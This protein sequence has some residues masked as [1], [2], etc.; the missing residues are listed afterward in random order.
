MARDHD[1]ILRRGFGADRVL[2]AAR[3]IPASAPRPA[4]R[5]PPVPVRARTPRLPRQPRPAARTPGGRRTLLPLQPGRRRSRGRGGSPWHRW[6]R[7]RIRG[8]MPGRV[9]SRMRRRCR[10]RKGRRLRRSAIGQVKVVREGGLWRV[11]GG[12]GGAA[13][14]NKGSGQSSFGP[15]GNAAS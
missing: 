5:S 10:R 1:M 14:V 9:L 6:R 15:H 7:R 11:E 3:S 12:G 4:S 8:G 13:L 2:Q